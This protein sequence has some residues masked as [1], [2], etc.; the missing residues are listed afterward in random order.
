[1][2]IA[3]AAGAKALSGD[4]LSPQ[5]K[6]AANTP[7][8]AISASFA[9]YLAEMQPAKAANA[10]PA[11]L[12]PSP[13][14]L[15]KTLFGDAYDPATQS[16]R[17]DKIAAATGRRSAEFAQL[18]RQTVA[19]AGIDPNLPIDLSI[20]AD[21]RVVIDGNHP[22]AAEITTL[23]EENPALA[24][25]Y[26]NVAAQNDH[27]AMLQ[28]GAVYV[29]EWNA[30]TNDAERQAAWQ[31]SSALTERLSTLFSGR[32]TFGA[33]AAIVESQQILRRMGFA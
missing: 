3:T 24:Q 17:L 33:G 13:G 14:Q 20:G 4:I 16:V 6:I 29:K 31:R 28:A 30:A 27:L 5:Q 22:Y 15:A 12:A 11:T 7:A 19:G 10:N 1:M 2:S 25:A 8:T 23:F 9:N 18:L 32:M 26:R 21:G